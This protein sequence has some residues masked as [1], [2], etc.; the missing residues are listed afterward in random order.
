MPMRST[1]LALAA[2]LALHTTA[3]AQQDPPRRIDFGADSITQEPRRTTDRAIGN[4]FVRDQTLLGIFLY[5]PAFATAVGSDGVTGAAAYLVVAGGTFFA[6]TELTR[7]LD[8][9]EARRDLAFSV[10]LRM[11]GTVWLLADA[12]ELGTSQ[13]GAVIFLGGMGGLAGGLAMGR[14]LTAGEAAAT[15]FGHDLGF[16]SGVLITAMT[17][18]GN[19]EGLLDGRG[20]PVRVATWTGAAIAGM[21]VGRR[22]AGRAMHNVTVG[23]VQ[24]HW[25]GAS[26]GALGATTLIVDSEPNSQ[27]IAGT[28]LVGAL[29]GTYLADRFIVRRYDH[30]RGEGNVLSLGAAAGA[31]M[32][33]GLGV[34]VGGKLERGTA[35]TLGL[36][37]A[38]GVAGVALTERYLQPAADQGK[39]TTSIGAASPR[40]SARLKFDPFGATAAAMRSPGRHAILSLTF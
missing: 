12:A 7:R 14:G 1:V 30:T 34:L 21:L 8:I 9:T 31:V 17:T 15:I 39:L 2:T 23:D 11:A 16:L 20:N 35:L 36:A 38:G 33:V 25:L 10:P 4:G 26:I 32:G 24:A 6:A 13:K 37:T 18:S 40:G 29:G 27:T 3:E 5:A 19:G 22:Y 28:L